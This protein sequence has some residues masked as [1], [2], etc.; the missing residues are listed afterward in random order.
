[1]DSRLVQEANATG[2]DV[3]RLR[4]HVVFERLLVRFALTRERRWV[5]KGGVAV[6]LRLT[7]RA[8]ATLDLDLALCDVDSQSGL[9]RELRAT[10]RTTGRTSATTPALT[11]TALV[12]APNP[13]AFAKLVTLTATVTA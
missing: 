8:R 4:R 12:T 11:S 3:A 1:L 9:V 2:I 6:E 10:T 13:S 7:D 5:L